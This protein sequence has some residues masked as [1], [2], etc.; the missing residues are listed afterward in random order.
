[1]LKKGNLTYTK[2]TWTSY[3]MLILA[4][5]YLYR[6]FQVAQESLLCLVKYKRKFL[7]L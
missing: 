3:I 5:Y 2:L 1:M 6:S 4:I 7:N